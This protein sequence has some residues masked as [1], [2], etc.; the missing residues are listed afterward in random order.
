MSTLPRSVFALL[1]LA[2]LLA[3]CAT[4]ATPEAPATSDGVAASSERAP[5]GL[6]GADCIEGG[7]HSVH[8]RSL[9]ES[10]DIRVVP[11]PWV[12]ADVSDDVGE[13]LVFSEFPDPARPIPE[14]GNMM[15]NYHATMW[16]ASWTL[17]GVALPA[18]TFVGFVGMRV[19]RPEWSDEAPTHHYLVT[20]VATNDASVHARLH[21]G[22][23]AAMNATAARATLPDGTVRIQMWTDANG[24]YDSVFRPVPHGD[25]HATHVRLWWQ[26]SAS[27]APHAHAEGAH[28]SGEFRP[29][30]LDL[31][32][33]GGSHAVAA[34]Q[35]YFSHTGT[36]H[37]APLPG[38]YGHTA[39]T[40]YDGFDR[41][42]AWGPPNDVTLDQA[43]VH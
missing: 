26:A 15:G 40:S 3:G 18:D 20:V 34:A 7:G 4:E 42:F 37:H 2:A 9:W 32:A 27:D 29:V 25:M 8:P 17:D 24:A 19:E 31:L 38:A 23:I 35:G 10:G 21:A 28:A 5:L 6:S 39:A 12:P 1:V 11:E 22:G 41:A 33:T 43:Y 16:C 13:Q 30:A 14:R 36:D